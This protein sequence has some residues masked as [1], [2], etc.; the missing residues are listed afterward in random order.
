MNTRK[1]TEVAQFSLGFSRESHQCS[2]I[3]I[4]FGI[5]LNCQNKNTTKCC[6][7]SQNFTTLVTF[8][9]ETKRKLRYFGSFS[10]IH[11]VYLTFRL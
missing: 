8:S 7:S 5:F 1:T 10:S 4:S 11:G 2:E 9:R 6:E 3:L